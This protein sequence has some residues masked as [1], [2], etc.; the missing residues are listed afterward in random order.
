MLSVNNEEKYK[1]IKNL[2]EEL[3]INNFMTIIYDQ[4]FIDYKIDLEEYLAS[5]SS[6]IAD[7]ED[8]IGQINS[9]FYFDKLAVRLLE[10]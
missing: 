1:E 7:W 5:L 3:Q 9:A 4:W 6:W 8:N 2:L 10:Y